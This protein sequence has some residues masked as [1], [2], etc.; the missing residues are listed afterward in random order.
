M[1]GGSVQPIVDGQSRDSEDRVYLSNVDGS[2]GDEVHVIPSLGAQLALRRL[3]D[4]ADGQVPEHHVLKR[5]AELYLAATIDGMDRNA[6]ARKVALVTGVPLEVIQ[7]GIIG[8]ASG[9]AL[10]NVV[11]ESESPSFAFPE[12]FEAR[13]LPRGKTFAS[14]LVFGNH[15]GPNL[16]W[17]R[18]LSSGYSV[19]IRPGVND[20]FT[21]RRLALAL[22]QA[23]LAPHKLAFLPG[24]EQLGEHLL[25][26]ADLGVMYGASDK[27]APWAIRSD[28]M[29]HGP[30]R[31]KALLDGDA[32][33]EVVEHLAHAVSGDA[34]I[35]CNNMSAIFTSGD[36]AA[37]AEELAQRLA[38]LRVAPITASEAVLPAISEGRS[39]AMR[40]YLSD[41][42]H[43]GLTDHSS[44]LYEGNVVCPSGDGSHVLR[45]LVLSTADPDHPL[46][47]TELPFPFVIVA[48]WRDERGVKQLGTSLVANLI[49]GDERLID[50]ALA[51]PSIRK[52]VQGLLPP[53]TSVPTLPDDGNVA[54]FLMEP[55]VLVSD[56][57]ASAKTV[58]GENARPAGF[59]PVNVSASLMATPQ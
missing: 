11:N 8:L 59:A 27:V 17:L 26:E 3:R 5:A 4:Q 30:G 40:T 43:R 37:I 28:M 42:A 21:P 14:V 7:R 38:S 13:W 58:P 34:G 33:P 47:G 15:P 32:H 22:L 49:T 10:L 54:G 24:D 56:S 45:P 35:R 44:Q 6:Y 20:P 57:S 12:G 25:R 29:I 9:C 2:T 53:W 46:L 55:K 50:E 18:A 36:H 31:S 19:A 23:G 1:T 16:T 51:D 48:P 52:V 41:F 39:A